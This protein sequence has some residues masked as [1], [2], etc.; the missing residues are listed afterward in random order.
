MI[1]KCRQAPFREKDESKPPWKVHVRKSVRMEVLLI[2]KGS[3][4]GKMC[5][6]RGACLFK[7]MFR[8]A[9]ITKQ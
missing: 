7:G 6:F 9:N 3:Q 2:E 5:V 8:S 4:E 1:P